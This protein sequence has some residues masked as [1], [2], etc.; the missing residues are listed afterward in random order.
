LPDEEQDAA[1]AEA[2]RQEGEAMKTEA[3]EPTPQERA[4]FAK[5]FVETAPNFAEW[6]RTAEDGSPAWMEDRAVTRPAVI[7]NFREEPPPPGTKGRPVLVGLTLAEI[8]AD[9]NRLTRGW[10]RRVGKLLFDVTGA[11]KPRWLE[12]VDEL[13]AW[14]GGQR[15]VK[16]A[17]GAGMPTK[18]EF[19][20]HLRAAA[21]AYEAVETLPH[22][23]RLPDHLY[24]HPAP[25]G[26]DGGAL[27]ALLARFCPATAT[28]RALLKAALLTPC[29]GGRPGARPMFLIEAEDDDGEGGR[30]VGKSTVAKAVGWQYGGHFDARPGEDFG[31]L[32]NRLLSTDALAQRVALLDN[33]KTLRFSWADLEGLITND[34]INGYRLYVGDGRRPNTLTWFVTLNGASL[35]KDLAQRSVIIRL[36]RPAYAGAWEDE[37]K[38]F[39]EANRWAIFG[40]IL[41][42]LRGKKAE[43]GNFTRWS[44]WEKEVLACV[45]DPVACQKLL[46]ERRAAV[47]ADQ[48]EADL[49]RGAFVAALT[50]VHH[51][52]EKAVVFIPSAQAAQIVNEA[53]GEVRPTQRATVFLKTL[54]I[55]EL[56]KGNGV[57]GSRGW[58]W[59][60]RESEP[61]QAAVPFDSVARAVTAGL[62]ATS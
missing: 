46:A 15:P 61:G 54:A 41:A 33:V 26:G 50:A 34:T 62:G 55:P 30:G 59:I 25:T 12:N 21:R 43:L 36:K 57:D 2:A 58:R 16:W 47:D 24:L 8:A 39:I 45:P 31:R 32:M 6:L 38:G 5:W 28:D 52:P 17:S 11:Y 60:G 48:E 37:A 29:W 23:P 20:A 19:L 7:T 56:R 18:A 27:D 14:I 51:D 10:P 53:T 4:E 9:L 40:D 3:P 1:L 13:F 35:S 42:L 22:W 49:V 44:S